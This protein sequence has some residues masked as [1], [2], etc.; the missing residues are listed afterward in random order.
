METDSLKDYK[1]RKQNEYYQRD[2]EKF[3]ERSKN[4]RNKNLELVKHVCKKSKYYSRYGITFEEL[5]ERL[6][7]Q[8]NKCPCC[9][10]EITLTGKRATAVVDHCHS[11]GRVRGLLCTTCNS[12]LGMAK[13]NKEIL[14]NMIKYLE[15]DEGGNDS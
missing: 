12:G 15:K 13:D 4:F 14:F 11:S 6:K 8:N 2:K 5:L 3:K 1:R 9:N 7:N 10:T